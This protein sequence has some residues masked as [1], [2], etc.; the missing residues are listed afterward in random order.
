MQMTLVTA[1]GAQI[2]RTIA[3]LQSEPDSK[4]RALVKLASDVHKDD[5][6]EGNA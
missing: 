2:Y 4:V 6:D 1:E 3:E 5:D